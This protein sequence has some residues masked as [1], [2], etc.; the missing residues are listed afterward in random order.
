M[1]SRDILDLGA[2]FTRYEKLSWSEQV[3]GSFTCRVGDVTLVV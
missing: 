3:W 1:Y 2:G